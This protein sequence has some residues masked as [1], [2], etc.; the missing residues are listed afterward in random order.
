MADQLSEEQIAEFNEAFSLFDKD[1]DGYISR[2]ELKLALESM[3]EKFTDKQVE[4][5]IK[6]YDADQD[7]EINFNE[8]VNIVKQSIENK[9]YKSGSKSNSNH[10]HSQTSQA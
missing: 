4:N 5:I 9:C 6:S 8:F 2:T 3:Q 7:G 10:Q 1:G